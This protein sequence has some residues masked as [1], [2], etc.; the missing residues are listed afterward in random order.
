MKMIQNLFILS[1]KL[2]KTFT[3]VSAFKCI[4]PFPFSLPLFLPLFLH[5]IKQSGDGFEPPP[6]TYATVYNVGYNVGYL[7]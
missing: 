3:N 2:C 4:L 1:R 7:L 5:F 6:P